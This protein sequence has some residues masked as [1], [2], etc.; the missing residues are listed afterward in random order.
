MIGEKI[1]SVNRLIDYRKNLDRA[2]ELELEIQKIISQLDVS[3]IPLSDMPRSQKPYDKLGN[4]TQRKIEKEDEL[5]KLNR[6]LVQQRPILE[7]II[8]SMSEL[9][10][11]NIGT[12]QSLL[13]YYYIDGFDIEITCSLIN[14][15][16]ADMEVSESKRRLFYVWIHKAEKYFIKI[17]KKM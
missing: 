15:K 12:Y 9:N 14:T 6:S 17:Q 2:N 1:V 4:L 3:A 5:R 13:K 10:L 7:K 11:A 16:L 8:N